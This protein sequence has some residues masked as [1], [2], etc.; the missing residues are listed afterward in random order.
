MFWALN[1]QEGSRWTFQATRM[2]GDLGFWEIKPDQMLVLSPILVLIFIPMYDFLLYPLLSNVGIRRPLQKIALGGILAG[3]AFLVSGWV[4]LELEKTYPVLPIQ[5]ES[6]LRI[7]NTMPCDYNVRTNI[8][9]QSTITIE[10]MNY[11]EDRN[12]AVQNDTQEF[13]YIFKPTTADCPTFEGVLKLGSAQANSYQIKQS[14]V[15]AYQDDPNKSSTGDP[16][17]RILTNTA[18]LRQIR[19]VDLN[20]VGFERFSSNSSDISLFMTVASEFDII[21]DNQIVG[22]FAARVGGV[23]AVLINEE[24][25]HVYRVSLL[26]VTTANSMSMLW[27]VPQYVVMELGE[28]MFSVTG[29]AFSYAE[30]PSSMKSVVQAF[31]LLTTAVGN[32]IDIIVVGVEAFDSQAYEFFLFAGIMFVDMMV[33]MYLSYRYVRPQLL[34]IDEGPLPNNEAEKISHGTCLDNTEFGKNK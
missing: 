19:I 8:Y 23:Y 14:G 31:W 17:I 26:E 3:V 10:S 12:V 13:N 22:Q 34:P 5:G 9:D 29:L 15:V 4:E 25:E 27:L 30:A 16:L 11:F 33:F 28:V 6:Q 32:V 21:V 2:N 24:E 7:F 18:E 1:D 20:R